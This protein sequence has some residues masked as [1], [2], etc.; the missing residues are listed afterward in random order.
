M[1]SWH[2]PPPHP[3]LYA[4][5]QQGYPPNQPGPGYQAVPT[6]P[7]PASASNSSGFSRVKGGRAHYDSPFAIRAPARP[8][9]L[10]SQ[11]NLPPGARPPEVVAGGAAGAKQHA[12]TRSQTAVIEDAARP[13]PL[14]P[15]VLPPPLIAAD[16]EDS[17]ASSEPVR[18][19]FWF[20]RSGGGE[21]GDF[22]DDGSSGATGAGGKS[23][24]WPFGKRRRGSETDMDVSESEGGG[25]KSSGF[26][27]MRRGGAGQSSGGGGDVSEENAAPTS[28]FAVIRQPRPGTGDSNRRQST[29]E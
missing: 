13:V 26:M 17:P 29:V 27:V 5:Q 11:I 10:S 4:N 1:Q 28:S 16:D 21:G 22:Q 19:R 25:A 2:Q 24:L 7:A 18:R 8:S 6:A 20:G 23:S 12:R 14:A 9:P 15:S 3:Q